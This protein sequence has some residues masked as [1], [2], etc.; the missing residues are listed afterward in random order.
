MSKIGSYLQ[1]LEE[2]VDPMVYLGHSDSDITREIRKRLP[3]APQQWID[4]MIMRARFDHNSF[5]PYV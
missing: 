2:V 4:D 5:E 3:D 1:E